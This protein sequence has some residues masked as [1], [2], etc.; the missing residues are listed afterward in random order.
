MKIT[1]VCLGN[2]CRSPMAEFICKKMV[3]DAGL[4]K[5]FSITSAGTSGYHDGE[6]MHSGTSKI[7]SQHQISH[8]DFESK[9][10]NKNLFNES[11]LVL[12][13]D[14]SNFEDVKNKFGNSE[15]IK[16]I[17]DYCTD[18][19]ITY[20]PDP[21]YTNNFQQVYDILTDAITN[22]LKEI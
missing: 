8:N 22:L 20:V 21:W 14:D 6:F 3:N 17:T 15:K 2:I 19:S 5:D 10:I 13:M 9:K 1:F 16:K 4:T 7:L 11:D 12:V 18:K